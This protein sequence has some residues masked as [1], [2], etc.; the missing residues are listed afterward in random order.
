MIFILLKPKLEGLEDKKS[1]VDTHSIGFMYIDKNTS[2]ETVNSK[3]DTRIELFQT[4]LDENKKPIDINIYNTELTKIPK[5]HTQKGTVLRNI[6]NSKGKPL[7]L[8]NFDFSGYFVII[9]PTS[10]VNSVEIS[11]KQNQI[12]TFQRL[13]D[14]KFS[15]LQENLKGKC[16][17]K[18]SFKGRLIMSNECSLSFQREDTTKLLI[19]YCINALRENNFK[20]LPFNIETIGKDTSDKLY[21]HLLSLNTANFN[22]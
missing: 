6:I 7:K 21:D 3:S 16:Q 18:I 9:L 13:T 11:P 5:H 20:L 22:K 4:I 12:G 14:K 15:K 8:S 10:Q 19:E 1:F 17:E 2:F